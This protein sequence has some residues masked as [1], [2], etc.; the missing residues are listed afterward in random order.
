MVNKRKHRSMRREIVMEGFTGKKEQKGYT[1]WK[2][3]RREKKE[4]LQEAREEGVYLKLKE[5]S[6]RYPGFEI[7][8]GKMVLSY[9][10]NVWDYDV[11]VSG[12][13]FVNGKA[14]NLENV[15]GRN[16]LVGLLKLRNG[17]NL[18]GAEEIESLEK[19]RV[20][21]MLA[22]FV[23][24][25]ENFRF[26][27]RMEVLSYKGNNHRCWVSKDSE[28]TVQIYKDRGNFDLKS[29]YFERDLLRFLSSRR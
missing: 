27:R 20:Y 2:K 22:E 10:G 25:H 13:L 28:L 17:S 23:R 29:P 6:G 4:E 12:G 18:E 1:G 3:S 9:D 14:F 16:G 11:L 15:E 26:N 24:E 7:D 8:G 5:I 19:E 21:G